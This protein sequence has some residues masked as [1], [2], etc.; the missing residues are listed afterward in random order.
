MIITRTPLRIS[1]VGGGSDLPAFYTKETGRVVSTAIN[2]YVFIAFNEKFDG[3]FRIGYSKT[4]IVSKPA[5]IQN[6]RVRAALEYFKVKQ[7]LEIVSVADVSAGTGLGSSSSFTVGLVSGLSQLFGHHIHKER[8]AMAELATHLEIDVLRE[9]IGKQ[10]QYAAAYGGFNLIEFYSDKVEVTP[11]AISAKVKELFRQYLL[12]VYTGRL[13]Q[14]AVNCGILTKNLQGNGNEF[15]F[16]KEMAELT[17]PFAEAL[18]KSDFQTLGGIMHEGWVLKQK[19]SRAIANGSISDLYKVG[20]RN[21]AWG[22]KL[23]G[24]GGGGFMLFFAP[25]EKHEQLRRAFAKLPELPVELDDHGAKV[26]F[27]RYE[28]R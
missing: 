16:Q 18:I 3:K 26:I 5:Q 19:T 1:F 14:A 6:T 17:T 13:R 2:K 4:E 28:Y 21:G 25:P 15:R 22:G 23:L 8:R 7:G 12:V 11:L 24:A 27:N 9:P 10:D 20:R